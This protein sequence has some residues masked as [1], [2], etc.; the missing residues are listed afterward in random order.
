MPAA[1]K[2]ILT[3]GCRRVLFLGYGLADWNVR[4]MLSK[5]R[6]EGRS[7]AIQHSPLKSERKIWDK[8]NVNLYHCDLVEF[9]RAVAHEMG[10][11]ELNH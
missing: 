8:L 3:I 4:V 11:P 7:W 2:T 10:L 9:A 5:W 1:L 6:L